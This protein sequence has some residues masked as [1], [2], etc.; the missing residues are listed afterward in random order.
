[1]TINASYGKLGLNKSKMR[2]V[3]YKSREELFKKPSKSNGGVRELKKSAQKIHED[4]FTTSFEEVFGEYPS[5]YFEIVSKKHSYTDDSA[6]H[7]SHAILQSAK[8]HVLR[9]ITMAIKYWQTDC[10]RM[11]YSGNLV[12]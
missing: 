6:V 4:C 3:V 2:N 5:N 12:I 9:F 10:V 11:L 7:F 1:M 8:L